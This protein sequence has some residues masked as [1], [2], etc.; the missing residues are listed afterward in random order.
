MWGW[1]FKVYD[2]ETSRGYLK[3]RKK[4]K[5][6]Q[7]YFSEESFKKPLLGFVKRYSE[8]RFLPHTP[9][10]NAMLRKGKFEPQTTGPCLVAQ[11]YRRAQ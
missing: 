2:K 4:K 3:K 8:Y 7:N 5:K 9:A 1:A 6:K 10:G 11:A